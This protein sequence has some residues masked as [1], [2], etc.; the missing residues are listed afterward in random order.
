VERD[1]DDLLAH[2]GIVHDIDGVCGYSLIRNVL[3]A[4]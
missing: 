3:E 4:G 1:R 2:F